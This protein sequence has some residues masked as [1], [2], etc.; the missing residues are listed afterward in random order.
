ML[1]ISGSND[2]RQ[3]LKV[4]IAIKIHPKQNNPKVMNFLRR[5]IDVKT[6]RLLWTFIRTLNLL[7]NFYPCY[8]ILFHYLLPYIYIYIYM[9]VCVCVCVCVCM[10]VWMYVCL[11][12]DARSVMFIVVGDGHS[13]TSS[14]PRRDWLHF[15]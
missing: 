12:Q 15:T 2:N 9:C 5:K 13:D 6:F 4:N 1:D 14:N 8:R 11:L 7:F 10:C 3:Y